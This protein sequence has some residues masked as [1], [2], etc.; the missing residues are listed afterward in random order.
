MGQTQSDQIDS[1]KCITDLNMMR[2]Y[3]SASIGVEFIIIL[4]L[5]FI[6]T[7]RKS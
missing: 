6:L 3:Y 5:L 1:Q 2:I 7:V 4:I